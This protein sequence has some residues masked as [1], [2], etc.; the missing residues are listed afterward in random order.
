MQSFL[1]NNKVQF[2]NFKSIIVRMLKQF[3]VDFILFD[4]SI[5]I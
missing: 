1:K 5:L 3:N 2:K 4:F